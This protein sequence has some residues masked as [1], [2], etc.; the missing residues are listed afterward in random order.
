[1]ISDLLSEKNKLM[2]KLKPLL[3]EHD[4]EEASRD[5]HAKRPPRPCGI[6][7]H[8]GI[9]CVF[10]CSYCYIYDM[11]FNTSIKPYPLTGLQLTYA[12]L[13]NKYFIPGSRGTYLAIGSITE[14]FHPL[15]KEKTLEYIDHIYRY[16]GNPTQFSTKL[17]IERSLAWKLAEISKG[18]ISPLITIVT[19]K[20]HS[21]LEP[22]AP[23]PEKRFESMRNLKE[24]GLKPFLFLRP[25]IPGLT[26]REYKEILELSAENGVVGVVA[27]SLRVTKTVLHRL[28]ESGIELNYVLRRLSTPVDKMKSGVQYNVYTS[29]IKNEIAKYARKLGLIFYP[30]ACMANLHTH[31]LSCW[32]MRILSKQSTNDLPEPEHW[33][34]QGVVEK[35][36]GKLLKTEFRQGVLYLTVKCRKSGELLI[37]EILRSKFL[38]CV[39]VINQ[40]G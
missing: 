31:G 28:R 39:K 37:S 19:L 7:I 10:E 25:I 18:K 4:A 22:R 8:P 3:S 32:K 24:S 27:G 20:M 2:N 17:H 5:H 36:G 35:L 21:M 26:E 9:G 12:L 15:L 11:G 29:D 14:P 1:M 30:S 34:I 40:R 6:T 16:L 33:E 13:L 23:S 38:S